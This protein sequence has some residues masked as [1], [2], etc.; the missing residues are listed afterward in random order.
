MLSPSKSPV[1]MNGL[2]Y[3]SK[4]LTGIGKRPK[5]RKT[6]TPTKMR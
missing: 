2:G 1:I 3:L 4:R 6:Y 5:L